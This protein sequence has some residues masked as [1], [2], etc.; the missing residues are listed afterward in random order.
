MTRPEWHALMD[1]TVRNLS[2]L[3]TMAPTCGNC[4]KW[5][6]SS[7][8]CIEFDCQPPADVQAAGCDE[9][10]FDGIPFAQAKP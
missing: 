3:H 2:R 8:S 7:S 4:E 6:S 1:A 5:C 10:R 9:W